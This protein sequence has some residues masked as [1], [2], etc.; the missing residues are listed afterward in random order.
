VDNS[1]T[2]TLYWGWKFAPEV[3]FMI[4]TVTLNPAIDNNEN[5][6]DSP[7]PSSNYDR[8]E[9]EEYDKL[10][11]EVMQKILSPRERELFELRR[12][13]GLSNE[14]IEARTGIK[15]AT[16]QSMV[17]KARMKLFFEI[18]KKIYQ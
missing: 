4:Y 12:L 13:D 16:I 17:S 2:Y 1:P 5:G 9:A 8:L 3:I 11:E 6:V 15:K 10:L 18:K 7:I 14:E